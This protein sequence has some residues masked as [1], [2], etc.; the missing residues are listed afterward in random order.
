MKSS[1]LAWLLF[2]VLI[3]EIGFNLAPAKSFK[4]NGTHR[5]PF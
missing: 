3:D 4:A 1:D 2:A 5:Y